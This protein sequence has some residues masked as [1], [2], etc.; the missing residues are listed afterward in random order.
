MLNKFFK[1]SISSKLFFMNLLILVCIVVLQ[2]LFQAIYFE[3]YYLNQKKEFLEKK[4]ERFK[5][6]LNEEYDPQNIMN[7]IQEIKKND[8]VSI[9][10]RNENLSGGI[11]MEPYMGERYIVLEDNITNKTY[12]VIIGSQFENIKLKKGDYIQCL[13]GKDDYGYVFVNRIFI[14]NVEAKGLYEIV[15]SDNSASSI[16]PAIVTTTMEEQYYIEGYVKEVI[17]KNDKYIAFSNID[18]YLDNEVKSE[19]MKNNKYNTKVQNINSIDELLVSSEKVNGGYIITYVP[20]VEVNDVIGTM[21]NYYFI[22]FFVA[23]ILV[24]IISLVYSKVMTKPLVAMS[25]IAKKISECDFK[26]RYNVNTEDEIGVLGNSLN[27]ISENLERSLRELKE[28]NLKLKDDMDIQRVQE[29][30]RKELIANISHEL[31]TPI[32]IIQGS[33]YGIKNGMYTPEMY[34]DIL[35]ET[36][37]MNSLVK[38]MLEVSK[39][40]SPNFEL[41]KCPFDLCSVVLKEY[42]KLK[43]I[44]LEK[45]LN[46]V[47]EMEDEAVAFADEKRINQVVTNLFTNAIKYTPNGE[48]IKIIIKPLDD[49]NKYIFSI[50]NFGVALDE[51]E[52]KK[53]WDSFYR[54]EKSRNKKFGGTGL[55]LAIVKRILELHNYEYGVISEKSSVRF[56]FII[57]K[58]ENY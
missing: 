38:E 41:S 52:I 2:L 12:K 57:S 19:I 28:A 5:E 49:E 26:Y 21:N 17:K 33:I 55:G 30:K 10:F 27:L 44:I 32:T 50:E 20:L 29:E 31:K 14:N 56:Y 47:L 23:L 8:N 6:L 24:I 18:L 9:A 54:K 53:V 25:K 51:G 35:E 46:I 45:K 40:E 43:S 3:K 37:K 7:F 42:D 48:T 4:I 58:C 11:G 16:I 36:N 22:V 13:G 39:L 34:E 15:P 1:K